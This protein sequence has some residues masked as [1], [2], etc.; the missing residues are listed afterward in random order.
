MRK[1]EQ[2]LE[3]EVAALRTEVSSLKEQVVTLLTTNAR[4]Q[5]QVDK[6]QAEPPA[7]VKAN[8]AKSKGKDK[9]QKQPRRKRAK[10]QNGAR[11]REQTPTQTIQHKVEHSPTCA[12][13]LR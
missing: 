5:A 12:N 6:L 3:E 10:D 4:L 9:A 7:F 13:P 11:R 8:T 2:E 1:R